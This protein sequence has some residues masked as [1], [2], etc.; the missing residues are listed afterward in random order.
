MIMISFLTDTAVRLFVLGTGLLLNKTAETLRSLI[1]RLNMRRRNR[2]EI[3]KNLSK[4][5]DSPGNINFSVK[6]PY[7]TKSVGGGRALWSVL[8]IIGLVRSI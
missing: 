8:G 5:T 1:S 6:Q 3:L 2:Q 4:T 7:S